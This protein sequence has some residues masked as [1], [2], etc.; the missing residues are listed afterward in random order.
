MVD[1]LTTHVQP[2]TASRSQTSEVRGVPFTYVTASSVLWVPVFLPGDLEWS[3][4]PT[5]I[6]EVGFI[7]SVPSET[8][9]TERETFTETER[10]QTAIYRSTVQ[11]SLLHSRNF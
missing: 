4:R 9:R 2:S 8:G 10:D 3:T 1:G 11:P 5:R 7:K 6:Q